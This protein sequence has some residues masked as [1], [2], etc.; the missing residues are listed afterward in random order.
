MT[1]PHLMNCSHSEHGW[2]LD[3]VKELHDQK[4][5]LEDYKIGNASLQNHLTFIANSLG[6]EGTFGQEFGTSQIQDAINLLKRPK[7]PNTFPV[8]YA[9]S[10]ASPGPLAPIQEGSVDEEPYL[11]GITETGLLAL[12]FR[13]R[14]FLVSLPG[15]VKELL[16]EITSKTPK[17]SVKAKLILPP[18]V[19]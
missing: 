7:D 9:E 17:E 11:V 19:T 2:C 8:R 5:A 1:M 15:V 10:V 18:Q 3:C 6:L 14:F 13:S 4:E 12:A 16:R